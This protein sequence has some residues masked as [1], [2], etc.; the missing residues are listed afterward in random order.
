MPQRCKDLAVERCARPG[1]PGAGSVELRPKRRRRPRLRRRFGRVRR[2]GGASAP[3][4]ERP[5]SGAH[6]APVPSLMRTVFSTL[7]KALN[8]CA[9]LAGPTSWMIVKACCRVARPN[10]RKRTGVPA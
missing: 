3:E 1:H 6:H 10:V 2:R 7:S 4:T 9:N 8:L 5:C